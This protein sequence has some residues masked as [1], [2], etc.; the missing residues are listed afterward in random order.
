[1]KTK[2]T[3]LLLLEEGLQEKWRPLLQDSSL[4]FLFYKHPHQAAARILE[5]PPNLIIL[6]ERLAPELVYELTKALKT[7]LNLSFLPIILVLPPK[8]VTKDW[9]DWPADD[10]LKEDDSGEEALSRIKLAFAR[11]QRSA[12]NNPLT[13]LPGN[14]T[15]LKA[16]QEKI[17]A[18]EKVA[19]AYVDLDHFKPFNDRYG[20]ARG[21]EIL[22]MVARVLTNV[23]LSR[24][25][26]EGFVG[27]V[28]GDD[29]VF[30]CPL[31]EIEAI[32]QEIIKDYEALL[33][34]FIDPQDLE[35]GYFEGEDREGNPRRF[36]FPSLSIA[37]VSLMP[38]RFKHYGEVSAA[39]AQIKKIVKARSGN[40]Y[41][42]D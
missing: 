18:E 4:R 12:D 41:L 32:C 6:Q 19:I 27:H 42:V 28:G 14:T 3:V 7:N 26:A 25:G 11:A 8:N 9:K 24:Y 22:R 21:D 30:I 16:I 33:P 36:P 31:E 35:K 5:A 23:I 15:I 38:G 29:F 2:E 20:F 37:V 17:N 40:V 34:N 39:A 10:F 13:G 1:M